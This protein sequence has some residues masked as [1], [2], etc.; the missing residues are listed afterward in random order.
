MVNADMNPLKTNGYSV[1]ADITLPVIDNRIHLIGRYDFFD[2]DADDK[3]AE[4]SSY[5]MLMAGVV[6]KLHKGNMLVLAYEK[7]DHQDDSAGNGKVPE[8]D[9]RLGK[10]EKYQAVLQLKF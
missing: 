3:V 7:T 5:N 8:A 2:I 10:D 4:K 9:T 6:V 1:F